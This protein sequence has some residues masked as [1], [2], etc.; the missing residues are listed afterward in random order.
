M[1]V[2]DIES[3]NSFKQSDKYSIDKLD[4]IKDAVNYILKDNP[5]NRKEL[6][7]ILPI[8]RK[9]YKRQFSLSELLF[10]YKCIISNDVSK[11]NREIE[12]LLKKKQQKSQSGVIVVT[13]LTS[14]YPNDQT[15]SCEYDCWFCPEEPG[16]P[17]SYLLNEPGVLRANRNKFDPILQIWDRLGTIAAMGHPTDKLEILVLGGTFSSYPNDY[18]LDFCRDIYY[19]A[20]TFSDKITGRIIR[21]KLEL[22]LEKQMNQQSLT[23]IIGL[24]VETRPDRINAKELKEFRKMGVTRIQLGVQ[25]LNKRM[26][27]RVNRKCN[28]DKVEKALKLA[29]DC[30]FKVDIHI[31]PNMPNPLKKD[32]NPNKK[33]F[34]K[35]DIDFEFDVLKADCEMFEEFIYNEKWQADQWKI[36]PF[37]VVDYSRM[38]TEY[39]KGLMKLY[40]EQVNREFNDLH[41]LLISVKTQVPIYIRLNRI[42]RDIPSTYIKGGS[43]DV[44]MRQTLQNEMKKRGLICK[45]IRC[46]EV[47]LRNIDMNEIKLFVTEY[48][49][50]S[51]TEYFLSF[52][53]SDRNILMGFLRLRL[54]DFSGEST[55]S[56]IFPEL[57]NAA[58]IREL[59]VYGK[60]IPVRRDEDEKIC[61]IREECQHRGLGTLLINKAFSLAYKNGYNKIAVIS[62][63]GVKPYYKKF[64]FIEEGDYMIANLGKK[65]KNKHVFGIMNTELDYKINNTILTIIFIIIILVFLFYFKI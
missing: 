7:K 57:V 15:F 58:L 43:K 31:M 26:L 37:E 30:C 23:R 56:I 49:A 36:Y 19:A 17:R 42:I 32:V 44:N 61:K 51:G 3:L 65:N 53:S 10:A 46:R 47:G 63:E 2:I 4:E 38:L 45:C 55:S 21:E 50:S 9:K 1:S 34:D 54:S 20:N 5:K 41:E 64:G 29:K 39:N 18:R 11:I 24:T 60:T 8:F 48:S 35:D 27:D 14:P 40:G 6:E 22:N 62:G 13:I 28:P 52:E 59:H 25:H 16:Q 33:E 12:N